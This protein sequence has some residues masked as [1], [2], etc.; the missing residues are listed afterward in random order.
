MIGCQTSYEV[1]TISK[2]HE[3]KGTLNTVS[4]GPNEDDKQFAK[5]RNKRLRKYGNMNVCDKCVSP[6]SVCRHFSL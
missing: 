6:F 2:T 4:V 5:R 3:L 1:S